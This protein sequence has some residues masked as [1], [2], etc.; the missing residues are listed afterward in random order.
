MA[1]RFA[2]RG[3]AVVAVSR[4][5]RPVPAG[6]EWRRGD[7]CNADF[8]HS[9]PSNLTHVVFC[10]GADGPT[11]AAYRA[12]YI[13]ALGCLVETL[14]NRPG[15]LPRVLFTSSTTVYEHTSGECV[16][17]ET[18][19]IP[20]RFQGRIMMEA[21]ALL[22]SGVPRSVVLRCAGIYGQGRAQLVDSVRR[23]EAT[24]TLGGPVYTNR[25]HKQDC[26]A[27]IVALLEAPDAEGVYIAADSCPAERREVLEWLA[28][29]LHAPA[30]QGVEG[31]VL[32]RGGNKRCR[33]GRLLAKGF[34]LEF[35]SYRDGYG[36]DLG[37]PTPPT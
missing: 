30:P 4:N 18:P 31:P 28:R 11:E 24:Y 14:R 13:Q 21:E 2:T 37:L 29:A 6:V 20:R 3:A 22:L 10:A 35:P 25:I 32:G 23:G 12:I 1:Q 26:A 8:V 16:D 36:H 5:P 9:L 7:L 19:T 34:S 33:N 27:A 15:P 17:E